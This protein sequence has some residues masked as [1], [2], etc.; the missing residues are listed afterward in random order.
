MLGF[1]PVLAVHRT[2]SAE[3]VRVTIDSE[4]L[5]ATGIHRFWKAGQGWVTARDLKPGDRVRAVG[6]VSEVKAVEASTS[7][8]VYNLDVADNHDFFVGKKGLLVHDSNFVRPI[9]APFDREPVLVSPTS[10]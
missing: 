5:V 9:P 4:T 3:T 2:K 8:P 10:R 6:S 7:Q 1:Q